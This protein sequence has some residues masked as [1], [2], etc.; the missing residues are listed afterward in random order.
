MC[1]PVSRDLTSPIVGHSFVQ[2]GFNDPAIR[3][4][5]PQR[6]TISDQ[7]GT[8]EVMQIRLN[9]PAIGQLIVRSGGNTLWSNSLN[10]RPERRIL[11]PLSPALK[12]NLQEEVE[13]SITRKV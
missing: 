5:L 7:V 13:L 6:L 9:Q 8:M 1:R 2:L 10:S 11:A 3:F 12:A 4:V